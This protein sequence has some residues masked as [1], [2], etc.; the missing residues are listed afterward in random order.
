MP[1]YQEYASTALRDYKCIFNGV[2]P[3]PYSLEADYDISCEGDIA[4]IAGINAIESLF[5]HEKLMLPPSARKVLLMCTAEKTPNYEQYK[6]EEP[7]YLEAKNRALATVP[8]IAIDMDLCD[9]NIAELLKDDGK[10]T[11]GADVR[12]FLLSVIGSKG[13]SNR[14]DIGHTVSLIKYEC[15][16]SQ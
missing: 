11:P 14:L 3:A 5:P 9:D 12:E 13:S 1:T 6:L 10:M 15:C 8:P 4:A 2:I 16:S 7:L